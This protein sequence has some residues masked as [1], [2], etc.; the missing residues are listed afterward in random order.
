MSIEAALFQAL[1]GLVSGRV[2]PDLAPESAPR[3]YI[4]YQQVGGDVVN[5]VE[6]TIPSKRNARMQI[7]VWADTRLEASA[8]GGAVEDVLR[9]LIAFQA[10]ILGAAVSTYDDE[11]GLRGTRQDFSLWS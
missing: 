9:T 6:G 8:M 3:P 10:T 7:N 4:T 2:Y 11:T 5:F 1:R